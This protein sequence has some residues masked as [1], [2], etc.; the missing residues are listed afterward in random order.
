MNIVKTKNNGIEV[1]DFVWDLVVGILVWNYYNVIIGLV[2][3]SALVTL[4]Q[5]LYGIRNLK[6]E[7]KT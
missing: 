3:F 5:I 2:V 6:I 1:G 7:V 4:D